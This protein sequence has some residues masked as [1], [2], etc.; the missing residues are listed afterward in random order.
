MAMLLQ[1]EFASVWVLMW[2]MQMGTCQE[3]EHH[4]VTRQAAA[5]AET[6]AAWIW[7]GSNFVKK[8][9]KFLFLCVTDL[10]S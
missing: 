6:V 2:E 7:F 5:A 9:E 8:K 3:E 4:T 10:G 1:H